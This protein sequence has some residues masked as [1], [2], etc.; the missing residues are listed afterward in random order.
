MKHQSHAM[1]DLNSKK[2]LVSLWRVGE[3]NKFNLYSS[4][5]SLVQPAVEDIEKLDSPSNCKPSTC[6]LH[7]SCDGLVL[8]S[9]AD[10]LLE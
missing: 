7:C 9:I 5:L 3:E 6:M 2:F 1:N 8:L 10:R 4:S